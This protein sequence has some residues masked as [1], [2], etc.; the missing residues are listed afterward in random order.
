MFPIVAQVQQTVF[1][2]VLNGTVTSGP[3]AAF[4]PRHIFDDNSAGLGLGSVTSPRNVEAFV[5]IF[6]PDD[7]ARKT[8]SLKL[9]FPPHTPTPK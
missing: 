6:I 4:H 3:S 9:I 7:G 2:V 5:L 8:E 1:P